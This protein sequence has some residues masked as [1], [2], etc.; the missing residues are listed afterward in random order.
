MRRRLLAALA[1]L[2]IF[3]ML[4]Y[5]GP[6][7][8]VI[9]SLVRDRERT[10]TDRAADLMATTVG[11]RMVDD[12]R[13]TPGSLRRLVRPG[14]R[15]TVVLADGT[16]HRVG[17]VGDEGIAHTSERPLPDG[18]TLTLDLSGDRVDR[19]VAEAL[20]PVVATAALVAIV[21]V[22]LASILARR[23]VRPFLDLTAYAG[24]VSAEDPGPPPSTGM[25][26]TDALGAA[27]ERSSDRVRELLQRE[28]EFSA[29]ASHQLRTPLAA[30]RL[31]IEEQVLRPDLDDEAG[32]ELRAALV[33]VDRLSATVTDLLELARSG[34]IGSW[35]DVDV[36]AAVSGAV[37]RWRS[38]FDDADRPLVLSPTAD[39]AVVATSER[40]LRQVLDVLLENAL[41]HGVGEVLV[42]IGPA[43]DHVLVWVA[44][45]GRIDKAMSGRAF[46][47]SV[48][49]TTSAGSGIG[50]AL[51]QSIAE[52]SGARLSLASREPTVFELRLPVATSRTAATAPAEPP[53]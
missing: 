10:V 13:I 41:A 33:E 12:E 5:A 6:R 37:A 11:R 14:E 27:L 49:S 3:A 50:L 35:D 7:T 24:R 39:R 9:A 42:D 45:E 23:L 46:E 40:S 51:A 26:E 20:T 32:R 19:E 15:L 8:F 28:R 22:A 1:G 30:L 16:T 43:T 34:G 18:G 4:L 29:N 17:G 36:H 53:T 21:A 2:A 48:R 47:R 31:R 38:L 25:A 52:A 44:D